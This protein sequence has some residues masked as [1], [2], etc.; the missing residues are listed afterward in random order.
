LIG[1]DLF[2]YPAK[3]GPIEVAV[4]VKRIESQRDIHKR[5]DEITNKASKFK[6]A[7]PNGKFLAVVYYSF[8]TEHINAKSRIQT[9][10]IDDVYFASESESSIKS[11]VGLMLGMLGMKREG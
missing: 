1:S 5:A 10:E 6:K 4:D 3:D 11:A 8:P 2:P 7:F 9:D